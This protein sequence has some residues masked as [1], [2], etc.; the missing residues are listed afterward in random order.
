MVYWRL[1]HAHK[2]ITYLMVDVFLAY[3]EHVLV[4]VAGILP[5]TCI[6][7]NVFGVLVESVLAP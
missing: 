5:G 2:I 1:V 4:L 7:T 6:G 3:L